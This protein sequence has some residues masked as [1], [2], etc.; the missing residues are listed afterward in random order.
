[1]AVGG[2]MQKD[3]ML[4]SALEFNTAQAVV[5][6]RC[7]YQQVGEVLLI[8]LVPVDIVGV[9]FHFFGLTA[10]ENLNINAIEESWVLLLGW[11]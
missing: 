7:L 5:W 8:E 11:K 4:V 9:I 6:S 2:V 1:M 3:G 10:H